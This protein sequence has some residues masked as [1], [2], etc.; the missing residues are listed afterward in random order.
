MPPPRY[1]GISA[2]K[3]QITSVM[4]TVL[5]Q[6]SASHDLDG[7]DRQGECVTDASFRQYDARFARIGL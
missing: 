7:F 3:N 4:L 5:P 6:I 2:L 1:R